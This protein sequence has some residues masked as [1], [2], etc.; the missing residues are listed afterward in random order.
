MGILYSINLGISKEEVGVSLLHLGTLS[1]AL[2]C[3]PLQISNAFLSISC[4]SL[5]H[6]ACF[7]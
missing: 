3:C 6:G 5:G 7:L 4:F 1:L 2:C